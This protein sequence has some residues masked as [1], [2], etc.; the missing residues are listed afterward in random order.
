M[1]TTKRYAMACLLSALVGAALGGRF[2]GEFPVWSLSPEARAQQAT[3]PEVGRTG[4][5]ALL[6]ATLARYSSEEQRNIAVYDAAN[7]SV[8]NISTRSVHYDRFFG[9]E[10]TSEGSGSGSILDKEGHILTN[11]HVV[12]GAREIEVTL[13]S[14]KSYPA[15]VVGHDKTDDLAVLRIDSPKDELRPITFGDSSNL[16]VGQNVYVVGNPFGW[17]RTMSTGIISGLNRTL[18]SRTEYRTMKALIQ[19]D[20]AMNPGNS[21]GPLLNSRGQ[22]IGMSLAIAMADAR[23]NSGVG[24]AIPINRIRRHVRELIEHGR[25]T[26]GDIGVTAVMPVDEGIMVGK[27]APGGPAERAG[28]RPIRVVRERRRQGPFIYETKQ[29]DIEHA[30]VITAIDGEPVA[31]TSDFVDAIESRKPG[32]T[33]TLTVLRDGRVKK[34][35]VTLRAS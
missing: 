9:L 19:T 32:E 30:D 13:A 24:F 12:D 17:E 21:G 33:V 8:V 31:S 23:Q 16:K 2:V 25:V 35:E 26:R 20:A 28:L 4:Q 3:A 10:G 15:Q 1:K 34:I 18:P 27:L 11:F 14:G 22:M 29:Y 5:Q 7:P 6:T